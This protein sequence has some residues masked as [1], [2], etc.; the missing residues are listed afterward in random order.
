MVPWSA[1]NVNL[2][3]VPKCW[4]SIGE[5][6]EIQV[7]PAGCG[8]LQRAGAAGGMCSA[9]HGPAAPGLLRPPGAEHPT[10]LAAVGSC[11]ARAVGFFPYLDGPGVC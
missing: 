3:P 7:R 8:L 5:G 2:A 1:D 6:A 9:C 11:A 4:N 10:Q